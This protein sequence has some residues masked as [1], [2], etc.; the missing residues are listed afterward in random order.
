MII[1][2]NFARKTQVVT[3]IYK[4]Y[5]LL[6]TIVEIAF[7]VFSISLSSL[8]ASKMTEKYVSRT[9]T[10]SRAHVYRNRFEEKTKEKIT[11]I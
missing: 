11:K 8:F 2:K 5:N 3:L 1:F 7:L 10:R 9:E 6:K 4:N